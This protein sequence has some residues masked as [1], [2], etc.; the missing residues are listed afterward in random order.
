MNHLYGVLY[1]FNYQPYFFMQ[2]C[3]ISNA[4][5]VK[6]G[7]ICDGVVIRC[8]VPEEK[9]HDQKLNNSISE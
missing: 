8:S 4:E 9:T 6:N 2:K 3:Y 5:K 1:T 7:T